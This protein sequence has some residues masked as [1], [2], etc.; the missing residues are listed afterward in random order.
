MDEPEVCFSKWRKYIYRD[1]L[2]EESDVP[3]DYGLLG[4]YLLASPLPSDQEL[5]HLAPEVIYIGTSSHVT[6]RLD[7]SHKAVCQY[8]D[9]FGDNSI[10]NLYY[11]EW[12]SPWSNWDQNSNIGQAQLAFIHYT[13]RKLI[14][15]Y[16]QKHHRLP[17]F[18]GY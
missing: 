7:K 15:E 18:N 17:R 16:A 10:E 1:R 4:V 12:L 9:E 8:K 2:S 3:D 6:K 5:Y 13:E 11:S 14:W